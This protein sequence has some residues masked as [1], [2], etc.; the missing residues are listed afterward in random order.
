MAIGQFQH[1]AFKTTV[2]DCLTGLQKSGSA[3]KPTLRQKGMPGVGEP[4]CKIGPK[5]STC[6]GFEEKPRSKEVA[7]AAARF[8][9]EA[10]RA[11]C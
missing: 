9:I 6:G 4:G 10:T 3:I 1:T 8:N 11:D 7:G 5:A 2:K